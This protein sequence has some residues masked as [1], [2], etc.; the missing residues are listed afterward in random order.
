MAGQRNILSNNTNEPVVIA[1]GK[2]TTSH[3]WF[4]GMEN[5][6]LAP[7]VPHECL[8]TGVSLASQD[9]VDFIATRIASRESGLYNSLSRK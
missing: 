5:D 2:H 7:E 8:L 6:G 1:K 4:D 3:E 9:E